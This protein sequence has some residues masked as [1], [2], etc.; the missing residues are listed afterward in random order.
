MPTMNDSVPVAFDC[1]RCIQSA[2]NRKP[3]IDYSIELARCDAAA[4]RREEVEKVMRQVDVKR[5]ELARRIGSDAVDESDAL[6]RNAS[7]PG[8]LGALWSQFI[9]LS[10]QDKLSSLAESEFKG[11]H[12]QSLLQCNPYVVSR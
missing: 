8:I 1:S 10:R 5:I 6:R 3:A 11:M 7:M 2:M 9:A 12:W 4:A